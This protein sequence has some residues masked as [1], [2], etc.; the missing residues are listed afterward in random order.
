MGPDVF[1]SPL[2]HASI[3]YE[4]LA[5]GEIATRLIVR[6][7]TIG[8]SPVQLDDAVRIAAGWR[9]R[10]HT[11][12]GQANCDYELVQGKLVQRSLD[13]ALICEAIS[14]RVATLSTLE[15]EFV[16]IWAQIWNGLSEDQRDALFEVYQG[17]LDLLPPWVKASR[18]FPLD[19][20]ESAFDRVPA[21][22]DAS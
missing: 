2:D 10:Y 1:A 12:V 18:T 21:A 13:L 16:Q 19:D 11:L 7:H 15:R 5:K 6:A 20:E 4:I 17:E 9:V 3:G 8:L 22:N 14:R